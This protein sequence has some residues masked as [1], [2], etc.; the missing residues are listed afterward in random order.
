M[1]AVTSA[2][3]Y[4]ILVVED[5]ADSRDAIAGILAFAGYHVVTRTL[6]EDALSVLAVD[7]IDLVLLDLMLPDTGGYEV[8]RRMRELEDIPVVILSGLSDSQHKV[9]GLRLGADDYL[10]KP[11]DAEELLARVDARLRRVRSDQFISVGDLR[12]NLTA[13]E[14]F[15]RDVPINFTRR[16]FDVL[17]LFAAS[18]GRA[19][20]REE[21]LDA[22][23]GT[24]FVTPRNVNEQIRLIRQRLKNAGLDKD[25]FQAAPGLGY[26]LRF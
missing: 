20:S 18:P 4:T 21:V 15:L 25:I 2:Q 14:V 5:D 19:F 10:V 9:H 6:G 12:L 8:L 22:V 7:G 11:F 23:W 24:R 16:Q 26:R 17:V 1:N 3:K 13:R